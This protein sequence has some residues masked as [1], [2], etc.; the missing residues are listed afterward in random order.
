M[1]CSVP[2]DI[3]FYFNEIQSVS[4]LDNDKIYGVFTTAENSIAGSAVCSFDMADVRAAFEGPFKGQADQNSNWLPVRDG[5]EVSSCSVDSKSLDERSLNFIKRHSLM[6]ES[7]SNSAKSPLLVKTSL[8]ERFTVIA[9]DSKV[10]TPSG[11]DYDVVYV[12]TTRGK[13]VKFVNAVNAYGD[14]TKPVVV[15]E[16]QAFP[17]HVP[18]TN[19]QVVTSKES[20]E[21]R[22]VV[23]GDHEVKSLP[24]HRCEAVQVQTCGACVALQDP[25]CAWNLQT[26]SCT[27]NFEAVDASSLVQDVF[28]GRH[29]ACSS[30]NM[31]LVEEDAEAAVVSNLIQGRSAKSADNDLDSEDNEIDIVIDI[32]SNS[33]YHIEEVAAESSA[34]YTAEQLTLAVVLVAF[35]ALFIGFV[36]GFFTSKRCS[37]GDYNS[38]GHHY[39]ETQINKENRKPRESGYT[40]APCN[41]INDV[42]KNSNLLVNVPTK[43]DVG[44]KNVITNVVTSPTTA[45]ATSPPTSSSTPTP[46]TNLNASTT[47]TIGRTGTLCKKVYL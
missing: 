9:V 24:L 30:D 34:N 6:D 26:A 11:Q 5:P 20:D 35:F 16:I 17:Y 29:A 40:S 36:A 27:S 43:D 13:I 4:Q 8:K 44:E 23:L 15:E 22:L 25:H 19:L 31:N 3:P 1:N 46:N 18:V 37:K 42:S 28:A 12:G 2:G 7:V 33:D 45:T 39:L 47:G 10:R 41:N 21:R 38:C 14:L 32:H